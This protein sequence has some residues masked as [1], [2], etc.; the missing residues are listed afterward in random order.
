MRGP[1]VGMSI[2]AL[3]GL[4]SASGADVAPN[5]PETSVSIAAAAN[6]AYVMDA[7][8]GGFAESHPRVRLITAT[9]ASGSLVAQI[10]NGAPYD[11]FL[12]ADR[13]FAD[14]LVQGG[15]GPS[16]SLRVFAIGRLA[17]WTKKPGLEVASV[18]K[19]VR[20]PAVLRIAIANPATAPYGLA[21][22]QALQKLGLW[23]A[24]QPK[25]VR[26][27]NI[28][29]AAEFVETGNAD[30]GFVAFSLLMKQNS[31]DRGRWLEI[32]D[33]LY[34]PL[35]Q[36]AVLTTRGAGNPEAKNYIDFLGS[37]AAGSILEAF[38]YRLPR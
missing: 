8:N 38:G 22:Q 19:V 4:L 13:D 1:S 36:A 2:L 16:E 3:A 37:P 23:E 12:S 25:L 15:N 32:P 7:L 6:L 24:A 9:G 31:G 33:S 27:E 34:L 5:A 20:D 14:K 28:S 26:G 11:V 10:R 35:L 18:E 29:Q 21:A 30:V 17:L